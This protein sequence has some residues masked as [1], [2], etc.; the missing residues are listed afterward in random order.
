MT[1]PPPPH[2]ARTAPDDPRSDAELFALIAAE[3]GAAEGQAARRAQRILYQRHVRYLYGVLQRQRSRLLRI[4]GLGVD[5]LV[6]DTFQ[7][8]FER[9]ASFSGDPS[10]DPDRA[11]RRTRAWLGRI[12]QNLVTDSFRRYREVSASHYLEQVA[13]PAH[14]EGPPSSRPELRPVRSALAELSDR[15]QD[16]LRVSALYFKAEGQGRLPNA[17]SEEL[18]RRWAISND[19]VRAIRSRALKKLRA[20]L[21]KARAVNDQAATTEEGSS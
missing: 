20:A 9:A 4:A 17:V 1:P 5:D 11:R 3:Q 8:A 7:R 14:D 19:N 13:V 21:V 15:E 18:G 6:Q 10:H 16:I 2:G 12:A